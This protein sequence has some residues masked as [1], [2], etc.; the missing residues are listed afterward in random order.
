MRKKL[1][2]LLAAMTFA[3]TYGAENITTDVVV[4]GGGGAGLSAAI[5]AREKRSRS[6]FSRKNANVR[7]KY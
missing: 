7:R 5:A 3:A 4:V 6:C 1:M 2:C